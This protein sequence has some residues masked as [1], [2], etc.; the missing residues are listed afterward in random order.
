MVEGSTRQPRAEERMNQDRRTNR[1]FVER[2]TDWGFAQRKQDGVHRVF[3]GP[4]GGTLRVVRSLV[5]RA[6][7]A[8]VEKAAQLAGVTVDR[9]WTGPHHADTKKPES[10]GSTDVAASVPL[11]AVSA[12]QTT[13][14]T[15]PA[16]Q[17]RSA[18]RDQITSLV[19]GVHASAD[20]PLGFDQVVELA[21]RSVT[22]EQVRTASAHLCRDG[23]LDRI[24]SGVYQ[25]SSGVRSRSQSRPQAATTSAPVLA[26]SAQTTTATQQQPP[27]LPVQ[28]TRTMATDLFDQ[29][30]PSGVRMTADLLADVERWMR[31]TEKLAQH[32]HAS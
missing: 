20:R 24:R 31:L 10:A 21:D 1:E 30:F 23:D 15:Q 3:R 7:I 2:L 29:L 9:F 19:L 11:R 18:D 27:S 25:W 22:R 14:A 5:G 8:R 12:A 28:T 17:R 13:Q 32:A 6:D 16:Q 26:P 4:H